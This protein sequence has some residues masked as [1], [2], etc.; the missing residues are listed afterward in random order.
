MTC[1]V[2]NRMLPE[3][4]TTEV[5]HIH[6]TCRVIHYITTMIHRKTISTYRW[7]FIL[8]FISIV[9]KELDFPNVWTSSWQWTKCFLKVPNTSK[10]IS[11]CVTTGDVNQWQKMVTNICVWDWKKV[12]VSHVQLFVTPWIHGILHARI[13]EWVAFPFSRGSSQPRDQTQVSRIVGGF[14]TS[15]ATKEARVG[16]LSILQPI[17]PTQESNQG[18]LHCRGI[19]Y[20]LSY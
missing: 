19:L 9:T 8:T 2:T 18:L 3:S 13:L 7:Q 5:I 16:S 10:L 14:F 4:T 15:W 1:T 17:F 20:Q 11:L 12:K 6:S